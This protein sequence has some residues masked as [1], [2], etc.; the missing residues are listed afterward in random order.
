MQ[1]G[2]LSIHLTTLLAHSSGEWISSDLPVRSSRVTEAPHRL[3]AA[4]TYVRRYALFTLVGIAGENDL[5]APDAAV[6]PAPARPQSGNCFRGKRDESILKRRLPLTQEQSAKLRD[7]ML[8]EIRS[9]NT[10]Q[11]LV[12]WAKEVAR[13]NTL[14][15]SD[16]RAIEI[17]YRQGL[18][19]A[20]VPESGVMEGKL[21]QT[22]LMDSRMF[23][24]PVSHF[25]KSRPASEARR[26]SCSCGDSPA[27]FANN[28]PVILIT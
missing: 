4:L 6:G 9:L 23:Q 14:L 17:A 12:A 20:A 19:E 2:R 28:P 16:A 3:G 8:A 26:I 21:K 13:K 18:G 10:E 11:D 15:E 25:R 7:K 27:S 5:D 1:A 24:P 22:S